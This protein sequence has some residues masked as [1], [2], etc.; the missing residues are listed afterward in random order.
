MRFQDLRM[1]SPQVELGGVVGVRGAKKLAKTTA[2]ARSPHED[3]D[4]R[5]PFRDSGRPSKPARMILEDLSIRRMRKCSGW[6]CRSKHNVTLRLCG[7]HL[8]ALQSRMHDNIQKAVSVQAECRK[9][10]DWY[11]VLPL[12]IPCPYE[13]SVVPKVCPTRCTARPNREQKSK[14]GGGSNSQPACTRHQGNNNAKKNSSFLLIKLVIFSIRA[15][16]I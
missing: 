9:K 16:L 6:K 4:W 13:P 7:L 14:L 8:G 1:L 15:K 2:G 11:E 5:T 10:A 3:Q 12:K